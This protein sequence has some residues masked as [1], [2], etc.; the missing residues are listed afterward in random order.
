MQ[1]GETNAIATTSEIST[2]AIDADELS[3]DFETFLRLLTAQMENQDPL[4]PVDSQDFA[5]QL[6]TFSGVEQQVKTNDLLES[7]SA[8]MLNSSFGQMASWVGME[9]K[10]AAPVQFDGSA[11]TLFPSFPSGSDTA[12]LIVRA[13]NGAE[14]QRLPIDP[15]LAEVEWA[16]VADSG[17]PLPSGQYSFE[18]AGY[19]GGDL[20]E[21]TTPEAYGEVTEVRSEGGAIQIVLA[22]DAIV[23]SDQVTALRP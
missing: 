2:A 3:S 14:V 11:I 16:G 5:T 1:I 13:S 17:S 19:S 22:G 8:S 15:S 21:T 6:A 12:Q 20:L 23:G 9:A 10:V 18:V 4:N 7:L